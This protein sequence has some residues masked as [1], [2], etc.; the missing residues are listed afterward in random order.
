M[1][2]PLFPFLLLL[3]WQQR[4]NCF[5]VWPISGVA[6]VTVAVGQAD[7]PARFFRM[8]PTPAKAQ[9]RP[10]IPQN[11]LLIVGGGPLLAITYVLAYPLGGP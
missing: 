3:P 5:V 7:L 2:F 9:T 6:A 4:S 11:H 10:A 1:F 8:P